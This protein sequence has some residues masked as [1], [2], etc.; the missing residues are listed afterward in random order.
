MNPTILPAIANHLWQ[1]TLLAAVAW[2]LTLALRNNRARVRHHVW[3]AASCKFLVPFSVLVALGGHVQWRTAAAVTRS[4]ISVVVGTVGE[5]FSAAL[6]SSTRFA[7]PTPASLFPAVLLGLWAAG[8]LGVGFSWW[9]RWRRIGMAV[10]AASP[11]QLGLPIPAM[12]SPALIEPG[13]FGII[14]PVLLMPAGIFERLTLSQLKAVIT[15]ELCHVRHRDNLVAAMHMFVETVFWFHPLAWW[16]GKRMIEERE[17]ASDEEVVRLGNE[18]RV[19]AEGILNVCRLYAE[20]T[21]ACVSGV[22]GADLKKRIAAIMDNRAVVPL[23]FAK[24]AALAVSAATVLTVPAIVGIMNAPARS[25]SMGA[26][27]PKFEVASIKQCKEET[28]RRQ[29]GEESSPGRL[30]IGCLVLAGEDNTGLIQRAYVRYAGGHT[31]PMGILAIKGG[32]EWIRSE[33]YEINARAEGHP[34]IAMMEGPMLQGL[35]ED[36]FKLK[37]HRETREGPVYELTLAK[38]GAKL[39]PFQEGSCVQM[40]WTFPLPELPAGQRYCKAIILMRPPGVNAEGSTPGEFSKLLNLFLDRPV[41]D[42]TGIAGRFDIQLKFSPNESTPGL[43]GPE[44]EGPGAASDPTGPT[45]FTAIQEQLG[46]KLT[47]A[48]GPIEFLMIDHVERPSEN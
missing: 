46:L 48:K 45:I 25:Q 26:P 14:R 15:H 20:P 12:S 39:K 32:P 5:P 21:L 24:R 18:P 11:L 6:V 28:G 31:N 29:G 36:R 33:M 42:K 35:L 17:R 43:H 3:L 37:I 47:P 13:V 22:T 2:L 4:N 7:P 30:S 8:F 19:Y 1:S 16:I 41:I 38:G 44:P 27:A 23:N 10:R 40:P 34:S 9:I